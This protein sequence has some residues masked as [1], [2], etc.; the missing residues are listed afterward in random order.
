MI[1]AFKEQFITPIIKLQKIHTIREDKHDRW[2]AGKTIHAATGVRTPRYFNFA[3][4]P[5]VS[6]QK[7]S[8]I[9]NDFGKAVWIDNV[10]LTRHGIEQLAKNDGFPSSKEFWEWFS[11]E[12]YTNHKLIHWT[13][14]KY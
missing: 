14:F 11:E 4:F 2:E 9:N 8:M 3:K 7:I 1:L 6:T 13:D 5:C 12:Y 10:K